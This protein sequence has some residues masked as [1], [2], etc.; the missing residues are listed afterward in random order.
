MT[1]F[2]ASGYGNEKVLILP[3][4]LGGSHAFDAMLQ[5]APLDRYQY[6]VNEYRGF[7][8]AKAEPG[9]FTFR[10]VVT[11]VV[12][13]LDFLGWTKVHLVGHSVGALVAQMIA[14]AAPM[15]I[16][17]IVSLA[18]TT[19]AGVAK[20]PER[21]ALMTAAASDAAARSALINAGTGARYSTGFVKWL[22][23][24]SE[25]NC[26][27]TAFVKYAEDAMSTNIESQVEG[28]DVPFL[29]V[30]GR[31]DPGNTEA[32][33]ATTRRLYTHATLEVI[34]AGHYPMIECPAWTMAVVERFHDRIVSPSPGV[35]ALLP[36]N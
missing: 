35:E 2:Y 10:E 26:S 21:L 15:R 8:A 9:L 7:G 32:A 1:T 19:A 33:T 11:D 3:G 18:G 16:T 34:D 14:V 36:I 13:L 27:V 17:S 12:R 23:Q 20:S 6:V 24:R 4:L 31:H 28:S 22:S 29:A 25:G 5:F 30:V